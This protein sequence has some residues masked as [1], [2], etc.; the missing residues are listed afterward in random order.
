MLEMRHLHNTSDK[1]RPITNTHKLEGK[2]VGM[3]VNH[4]KATRLFKS[5][6]TIDLGIVIP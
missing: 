6:T 4:L 5:G 1:D 2:T 3:I